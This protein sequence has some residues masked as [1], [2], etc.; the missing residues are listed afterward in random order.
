MDDIKINFLHIC[1][2]AFF[3]DD[4]KLNIIGIFEKV[5]TPGFPAFNPRFSVALNVGGKIYSKK[6]VIEIVNPNGEGLLFSSELPEVAEDKSH[7]NFAINLVG[8][9]FPGEGSYK[10]RFKIDDRVVSPEREDYIIVEKTE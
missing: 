4:K 9:Q 6:K 3:S 8:V 10:I 7:S 1:D 5:K 2:T